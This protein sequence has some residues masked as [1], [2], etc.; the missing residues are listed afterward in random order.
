MGNHDARSENFSRLYGPDTERSQAL[1]RS[2]SLAPLYDPLS[3]AAYPQLTDK[4]A[5]KIGSSYRVTELTARRWE[6]FAQEAG[7]SPA[8]IRKRVLEIGVALDWR[9]AGAQPPIPCPASRPTA[10]KIPSQRTGVQ[11]GK[12]GGTRCAVAARYRCAGKSGRA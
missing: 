9:P 10:S 5:M 7:L 12:S 4:M 11:W 2:G 6:Q 1:R 8:Q 3:T